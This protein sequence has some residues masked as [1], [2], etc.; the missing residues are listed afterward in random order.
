MILAI[1]LLN[2][3]S[4]PRHFAGMF[5]AVVGVSLVARK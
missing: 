5:L 1:V 4:S 3:P 2:E